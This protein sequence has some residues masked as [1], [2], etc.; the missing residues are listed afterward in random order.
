MKIGEARGIY[1]AQIRSYQEQKRLLAK[2]KQ[3][4]EKKM[5]LTLNGQELF[6]EEAATL[7]L[8]YK[9]VEEKQS[10]YQAYMDKLLQQWT[11]RMDMVSSEQQ[12]DAMEE[13]AEDMGK[14]MEVA[15]RIMKGAIVPATDERKLMEYSNELYQAAKSIGAMAQQEKREKY[16]SLWEDEEEKEYEDPMEAADNTEA[17][18]DGPEIVEVADTMAAA[19]SEE[20]V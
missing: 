3:E 7:E 2:Q 18:A 10:E 9:A 11:A 17:F 13:Y 20:G 12:A 8:T 16:K 19:T 15:R 6:A 1:N 4:L 14:M 5:S